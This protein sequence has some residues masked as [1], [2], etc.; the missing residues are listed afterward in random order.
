MSGTDQ[1]TRTAVFWFA[2]LPA[3]G[4]TT[5]ARALYAHLEDRL[6]AG[7]FRLLDADVER[8]TPDGILHDLGWSP[9]ERLATI[10]ALAQ[11]AESVPV[12]VV[13]LVTSTAW[14]R[15]AAQQILGARLHLVHVDAPIALCRERDALR[16]LH[17]YRPDPPP[18][19]PELS[20]VPPVASALRLDSTQPTG[21][22]VAALLAYAAGVLGPVEP[23]TPPSPQAGPPRQPPR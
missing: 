20:W 10:T 18:D 13:T 6:A 22:C 1:P 19:A 16:S 9:S 3:S 5:L 8:A 2:G 23:V 21:E 4:K 11:A 15:A 12:A 17:A 7:T 14:E